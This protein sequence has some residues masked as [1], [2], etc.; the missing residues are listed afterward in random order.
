MEAIINTNKIKPDCLERIPKSNSFK[1]AEI[2]KLHF[3]IKKENGF[4]NSD[5]V[6][7]KVQYVITVM[8]SNPNDLK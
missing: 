2:Y 1:T 6:H 4:Q 3:F 8:A 5:A 7:L